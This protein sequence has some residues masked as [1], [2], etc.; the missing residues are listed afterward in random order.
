MDLETLTAAVAR[1]CTRRPEKTSFFSNVCLYFSA[2]S[3]NMASQSK[4]KIKRERASYFALDK[5]RCGTAARRCASCHVD[6]V[7]WLDSASTHRVRAPKKGR[8]DKNQKKKKG[9]RPEDIFDPC[10]CGR[11]RRSRPCRPRST[12]HRRVCPPKK[13]RTSRKRG[14][15]AA[16][17]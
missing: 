14:R 12:G 5:A 3:T 2:T 17:I 11:C 4:S 15:D 7:R 16:R 9:F 13:V 10:R 6:V 8:G 1:L